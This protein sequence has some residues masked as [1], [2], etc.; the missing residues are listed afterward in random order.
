MQMHLYLACTCPTRPAVGEIRPKT[1]KLYP[2]TANFYALMR[3]VSIKIAP[4]YFFCTGHM[5]GA[6]KLPSSGV[7][8]NKFFNGRFPMSRLLGPTIWKI[9]VRSNGNGAE[10]N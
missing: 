6:I 4:I 2:Q 5:L 9:V 10:I 8:Q 3:P 7:S 1:L